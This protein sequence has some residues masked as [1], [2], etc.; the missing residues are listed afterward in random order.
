MIDE[1]VA[2][3]GFPCTLYPWHLPWPFRLLIDASYRVINIRNSA[4]G[5]MHYAH[6]HEWLCVANEAVF[7]IAELPIISGII[8]NTRLDYWHC[9]LCHRALTGHLARH[10]EEWQ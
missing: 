10:P 7:I 6:Q 1:N 9:K 5:I 4:T 3:T 2:D 8:N